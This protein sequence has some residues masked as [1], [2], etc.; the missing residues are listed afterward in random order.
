MDA[1][2]IALLVVVIGGAAFVGLL[3]FLSKRPSVDGRNVDGVFQLPGVDD[4][5]ILHS[6]SDVSSAHGGD[7]HHHSHHHSHDSSHS[8]DS[9]HYHSDAHH[10]SDPGGHSHGGDFGGHDSGGHDSGGH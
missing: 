6:S 1:P 2:M 3:F 5:G 8:S 4:D 7:R 9:S 10:Y